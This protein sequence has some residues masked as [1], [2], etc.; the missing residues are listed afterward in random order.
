MKFL[1]YLPSQEYSES[2]LKN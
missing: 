1:V 2:E